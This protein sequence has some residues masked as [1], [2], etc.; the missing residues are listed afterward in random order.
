LTNSFWITGSTS[1]DDASGGVVD[2]ATAGADVLVDVDEV[3]EPPALEGD[4]HPT[5]RAIARTTTAADETD[6]RDSERRRRPRGAMGTTG[7]IPNRPRVQTSKEEEL[8]A[9]EWPGSFDSF[10]SHALPDPPQP[11]A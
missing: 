5:A 2:V 3:P 4:E 6:R 1:G 8:L 10:G 9:P 11:T 7:L